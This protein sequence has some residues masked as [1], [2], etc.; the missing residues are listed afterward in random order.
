MQGMYWG[1]TQSL[2]FAKESGG[3]VG[4]KSNNDAE[5]KIS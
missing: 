5:L 2:E 4:E 3:M 1:S